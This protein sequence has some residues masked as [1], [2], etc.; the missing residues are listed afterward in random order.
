MYY[1]H[2]REM[3]K[4][5]Q[6]KLSD[7]KVSDLVI[8]D[9]ETMLKVLHK[10]LIHFDDVRIGGHLSEEQQKHYRDIAVKNLDIRLID[11]DY[12]AQDG[13][14]YTVKG[15]GRAASLS[16]GK[17]KT[18]KQRVK[19]LIEK[20]LEKTIEE[21]KIELRDKDYEVRAEYRKRIE[22]EEVLYKQKED[23]KIHVSVLT[24]SLLVSI[25]ILIHYLTL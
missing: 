20:A 8:A 11:I 17:E 3:Q 19:E 16:K 15:D 4:E 2:E 7:I 1:A 18:D 10:N 5:E 22:V 12:T 23:Y 9:A 14:E 21:H 13:D 6:R 25:G 24:V